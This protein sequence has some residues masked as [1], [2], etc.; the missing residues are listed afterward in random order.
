MEKG[1]MDDDVIDG[2]VIEPERN[3]KSKPSGRR[4]AGDRTIRIPKSGKDVS[5]RP[6]ELDSEGAASAASN[7]LGDADLSPLLKARAEEFTQRYEAL[8]CAY[9]QAMF[10]ALTDGLAAMHQLPVEEELKTSLAVRLASSCS[11]V[12]IQAGQRLTRAAG[13]TRFAAEKEAPPQP[14]DGPAVIV[15]TDNGDIDD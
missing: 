5:S 11:E 9:E 7:A 8:V 14:I 3:S 13:S 2:E 4:R 1:M 15:F 12:L 10:G 6:A